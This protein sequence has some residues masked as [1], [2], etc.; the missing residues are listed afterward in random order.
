MSAL[1][2][3]GCSKSIVAASCV[4]SQILC[5]S[6]ECVSQMNGERVWCEGK[7]SCNVKIKRHSVRVEC[8][9]SRSLL[10]GFQLLIGMDVINKLGGVTVSGCG[11]S[12]RFGCESLSLEQEA[13]NSAATAVANEEF[14]TNDFT[15]VF[16]GGE[17]RV[18]WNWLNQ[19]PPQLNREVSNYKVA[20]HLLSEFEKEVETWIAEG[21]LIPYD[22]EV[23]AVLPLMAVSQPQKCK[24]RPVLDYRLLNEHVSSHTADSLVCADTLRQ[25]RRRGSKLA[26]LDLRRAYL[27]IRVHHSLWKYQVVR[28]RGRQYCLTRLGFGLNVAP[29]IM[30]HIVS[31]VL[32]ADDEIAAA[33]DAYIDDIIV[34]ESKV[35]AEA[36]ADHLSRYGLNS[37]APVPLTKARVL[38][39]QIVAS[40]DGVLKWCR[41][42]SVEAPTA[43]MSRRQLFSF[44]GALVGHFP[45]AGWLRPACSY[46]KRV[47]GDGAW[48]S[49]IPDCAQRLA[50]DLWSRVQLDDPAK[51]AWE[52]TTSTRVKV[53]CDASSLAVGVCLEDVEHTHVIEDACWMRHASDVS[54]INLAELEAV[55]KGVNLAL[56]WKFKQ[57]EL[58]TD[59]FAVHRWLT[60]TLSGE[61]RV[62]PRGLGE[63]LVRRRLHLL[64]CLIDEYHLTVSCALVRSEHNRADRLTRVP[65]RWL[66]RTEV[67]A[68]AEDTTDAISTVHAVH[69]LHHLGIDRTL[70]MLQ[71]CYPEQHFTKE[72]VRKVINRC[73]QCKSIDP[74]P[75]SSGQGQLSVDATWQRL[76]ADV[77]HYRGAAF[78]SVIDCGPGRFAIWKPLRNESVGA[79]TEQVAE[80]FRERGPPQELLLDNAASFKSPQMAALCDKWKVELHFRCAH[81]PSGNGIVERHHRTIK[82]MASRT[83]GS[84]LEMVFW[85]N[86]S[87]SAGSGADQAP[88]SSV[89]N[90]KWR[91]P[92]STMAQNPVSKQPTGGFAVGDRVL[93]RPA[94]SRCTSRWREGTVT[95]VS[96]KHG[97][98]V[99]N[100]H[101]HLHDL[102]LVP[103]SALECDEP[104][105]SSCDSA[106]S[107]HEQQVDELEL[108]AP[109]VRAAPWRYDAL[110]YA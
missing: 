96:D 56:K 35:A 110:D 24:V 53:W 54:H 55:L 97:V 52:A 75:I 11:R 38:G 51:G 4:D 26:V 66:H 49:E 42:N 69:N 16:S 83:S 94:A 23:G 15:A 58:M 61:K 8:I 109:R 20:P 57:I 34:D 60:A 41:G 77:T 95:A 10:D 64:K 50:I 107:E 22:G 93:A 101:R 44:C 70:N 73:Y 28:F 37:K 92:L 89:H 74:A 5:A 19:K 67:A 84:P 78:L 71:R 3:T 32:S 79:V 36:V 43:K 12:V 30:T 18:K 25:W 99:D 7:A 62:K 105:D 6:A 80:I 87:S 39:L 82:R 46:V 48:N 90:Y 98:E 76:A 2:D 21:I 65:Q 45:V 81:R 9:V 29:R 68:V 1:L 88:C 31:R 72:L 91:S 85:Y 40:P 63:M 47:A 17:W 33:T 13:D 103:E 59:S 14:S 86:F 106:D 102:R 100:F 108:R 104:Q 27:Q